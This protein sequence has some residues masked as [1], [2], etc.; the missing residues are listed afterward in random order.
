[1]RSSLS[2][3]NWVLVLWQCVAPVKIEITIVIICFE[4]SLIQQ[5]DNS[6]E[7][8]RFQFH[9]ISWFLFAAFLSCSLHCTTP[10]RVHIHH[11]SIK[12]TVSQWQPLLRLISVTVAS[13]SSYWFDAA[14]GWEKDSSDGQ[15]DRQLDR[16]TE[17]A[18]KQHSIK[19]CR[20]HREN[21]EWT[22]N[23]TAYWG[24][25]S[26]LEFVCTNDMQSWLIFS[27]SMSHS[28]SRPA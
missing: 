12:E 26:N 21:E 23:N 27:W 6:I 14:W 13:S 5:K 19:M 4:W 18:R 24:V 2:L 16:V 25:V 22:L 20:W 28:V 15:E 7:Y 8:N 9:S 11:H 3:S 10:H 17:L 1:M